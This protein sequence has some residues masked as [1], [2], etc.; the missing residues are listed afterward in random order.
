MLRIYASLMKASGPIL[1]NALLR[2]SKKGR[3]DVT[4]LGERM[5][6][7]VMN[8]PPGQLVWL[9]AASVGEAQSALI[10]I[11]ALQQTGCPNI[12]VTTGTVTSARLMAQ[13]LPS[14]AFHQ[15]YPLD[16]PAW[17]ASFL[18]HWQPDLVLWMESE[19]WPNM[20]CAV[21]ERRI[22]AALVNARL[23]DRSF[24]RWRMA[25]LHIRTILGA[26]RAIFAQTGKDAALFR[27]LGA[28]NV[29]VSGNLKYC[30][31][32]L[33]CDPASLQA[34][35]AAV[36]NRPLWLYAST[37][38]GEEELACRLHRELKKKIPDL[39]T[40]IV[41]RH[42][43]RGT[44]VKML[45]EKQSLVARLRSGKELPAPQDD[46]YIGDTLGEMGLF[47]RTAPVACIG[48]SFSYDGGGGHNPIEA[49]QL[50][51]AIM[52]GPHVQNLA[53]IFQEMDECGASL[54]LNN[55]SEFRTR[56]AELLQDKEMLR[57]L[58]TAAASFLQDKGRV[59][60]IIMDE[61][62][63]FAPQASNGR[64]ACG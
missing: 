22:P 50:G 32:P 55:E 49:A 8:R 54:L 18:N 44:A 52:H 5:G 51:C 1:R 2:R 14:G 35:R 21:K 23:S 38:E 24:R 15:F 11:K 58:Q 16:H 59:L 9:H 10:L 28:S 31:D 46:I 64:S 45:C 39:M 4:R 42:P 56:L 62:R 40:V 13:R 29:L 26:F 20:L 33:P 53:T 3:E 47:Y 60:D 7:Y 12:L 19:L 37:H 48:R 27:R 30:A 57:S 6:I 61:I 25:G 41:P 43:D 17:V 63:P 34:L 36:Q